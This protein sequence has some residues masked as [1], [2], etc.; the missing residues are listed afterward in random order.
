MR[1]RDLLIWSGSVAMAACGAV[2]VLRVNP[3]GI[4][5]PCPLRQ[6]T[7]IPCPTCGGTAAFRALLSGNL[8]G[9]IRDNPMVAAISMLVAASGIGAL[10][11]L[12]WA[13]RFRPAPRLLRPATLAILVAL[14]FLNWAYLILRSRL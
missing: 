5:H 11:V 7:G 8:V 4:L 3:L 1:R 13:D 12:P 9:A 10:A 2:L 6:L 14:I